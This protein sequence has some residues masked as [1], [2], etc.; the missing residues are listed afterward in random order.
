MYKKGNK[1]NIFFYSNA[2]EVNEDC[3]PQ[4]VK[5]GVQ[6]IVIQN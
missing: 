4:T 1:N 5:Q 6:L 2:N 3:A